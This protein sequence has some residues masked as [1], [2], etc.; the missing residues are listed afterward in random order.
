MTIERH[1]GFASVPLA[2]DTSTSTRIEGSFPK[3]GWH[4]RGYLPHCEARNL[5]F[6]TFRLYDSV[7]KEVILKWKEQVVHESDFEQANKLLRLLDQ[8]EDAGKGSCYLKDERIAKLVQDAL[9]FHDGKR[10]KLLNWCIMPNHVHVLIEKFEGVTLSGILHSWRSFTSHKANEILGR[11]GDFWM[12]DYF[13]RFIRDESHLNATINYIE[14]N[15]V[16]AGLV[17]EAKEW[18]WSSAFYR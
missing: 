14:N 7:P 18:R 5:Q 6:I 4:S 1:T 10:Y 8:Y 12:K 16:K 11:T 3:V 2:G 15:P 9:L 17:S 13:D